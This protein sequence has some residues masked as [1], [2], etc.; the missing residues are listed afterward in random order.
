M[1]KPPQAW[2]QG[3]PACTL[4]C[5]SACAPL[6]VSPAEKQHAKATL[7]PVHV[8]HHFCLFQ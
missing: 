8:I 4:L 7:A 2:Q 3:T 1:L 6:E 5:C